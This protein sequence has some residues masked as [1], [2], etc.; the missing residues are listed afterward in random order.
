MSISIAIGV[1]GCY[2][3]IDKREETFLM[4]VDFTDD[5]QLPV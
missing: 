1:Y 3:L 2:S 5:S 4:P